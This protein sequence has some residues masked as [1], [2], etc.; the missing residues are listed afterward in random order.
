MP[1]AITRPNKIRNAA[2][3]AMSTG[4]VN[5]R[6]MAD[7][8]PSPRVC[9]IAVTRSEGNGDAEGAGEVDLE[10]DLQVVRLFH[11]GFERAAFIHHGPFQRLAD[12]AGGGDRSRE[13]VLHACG[14]SR[15]H[16]V[17]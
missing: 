3:E 11:G 6:S 4:A 10:K 5:Q 13:L 7:S 1:A 2:S 14:D 15:V 12:A 17:Q 8:P 16:A 9:L